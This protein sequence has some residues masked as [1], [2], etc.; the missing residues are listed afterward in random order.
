M[1]KQK[2]MIRQLHRRWARENGESS[3]FHK[4]RA[5]RRKIG[6]AFG[7]EKPERKEFLSFGTG[8]PHK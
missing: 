2:N 6:G 4:A 3:K 5:E 7:N 1:Y 8:H